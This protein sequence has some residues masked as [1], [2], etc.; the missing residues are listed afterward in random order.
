VEKSASKPS[1]AGAIIAFLV[2]LPKLIDLCL[3]VGRALQDDGEWL[4]R[5]ETVIDG[6]EKAHTKD[7]K[8]K[9]AQSIASVISSL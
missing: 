3:R 2:A 6:L 9:S 4:T 8:I 7:E 1:V 5:V